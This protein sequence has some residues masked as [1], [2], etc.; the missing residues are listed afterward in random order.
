ESIHNQIR[1]LSPYPG[2]Y[3]IINHKRTKIFKSK[4]FSN[5]STKEPGQII[6]EKQ[7][8][9]VSCKNSLLELITLQA[10][11]KKRMLTSEWIKGI[12]KNQEISIS[13]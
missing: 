9:V 6:I 11:G 13:S 7:R 10:E 2:A 8:L 1:A 12:Q 3:T 4:V 5:K